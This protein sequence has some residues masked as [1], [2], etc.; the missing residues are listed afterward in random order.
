[1]DCDS[2]SSSDHAQIGVVK[3]PLA[4]KI[5][6]VTVENFLTYTFATMYPDENLNIVIGPNGT[7]KSSI[8]AGMVIGMGGSTKVLSAL[9]RLAD[10]VKNGKEM[11][12]ITVVLFK[13]ENRDVIRFCRSFGRNNKST[14]TI[15]GKKVTEITYLS[16]IR[17][18]N[19]QVS[20]LC[21]FLPQDRV[22]DFAKQ[23]P[24]ELFRSTQMSVCS[25]EMIEH[26]KQLTE[27]RTEQ[28]D[29]QTKLGQNA[30]ILKE[31]EKRLEV[32]Q[33][34]VD[35]IKR[36]G[37]LQTR[38]QLIEKKIAWMEF[39]K[40]YL[41]CKEID[42][43]L[44]VARQNYERCKKENDELLKSAAGIV[45]QR[46]KYENKLKSES[47][48]RQ[49][50]TDE[51]HRIKIEME[52]VEDALQKAIGDLSFTKQSAAEQQREL[53]ENQ[54]L[55][56]AC[57][58]D[59]SE[60]LAKTNTDEINAKLSVIDKNVHDFKQKINKFITTRSNIN[61]EIDSVIRPKIVE[62][63]N[64]I[65]KAESVAEVKLE[66]LRNNF[67][68][69]YKAVMWLREN[70]NLFKSKIYEPILLE[71]NIK[72]IAYCK[73]VENCIPIRDL[74][75]FTCEDVDDMTLLVEKLRI[76]M[77]LSCSVVHSDASTKL[78]FKSKAP[79]NQF[80]QYGAE[81]YLID[82]IDG[83]YPILNYLCRIYNVHNIV[84]GDENLEFNSDNLPSWMRV[85]FTP[86]SRISISTSKYSGQRSMLSNAIFGKNIIGVQTS[87][88]ELNALKLKKER[89]IRQ[90][91]KLR[92]DRNE[93]ER[94]VS[95][96]EEQC[97][98]KFLE[99]NDLNK[100]VHRLKQCKQ[101]LDMQ[102][103][104]VKRM[105]CDQINVDVE[106]EKFREKSAQLVKKM[107]TFQQNY[108]KVFE[109][110]TKKI[111]N[112][113]ESR[114]RFDKFKT[115]CA[116]IDG[117]IIDSNE[118]TERS[119]KYV[120]KIGGMLD[121]VKQQCFE[122]QSAAMKLTE[123]RKPSD[124]KRFPYK[125]QFDEL[126]NE[127]SVLLD[128]IADI[129]GQLDCGD[130]SNTN[131]MQEYEERLKNVKLLENQIKNSDQTAAQIETKIKQIHD[132]WYPQIMKI[133]DTINENFGS[134][135]STMDC[136]GEIELIRTDEHDYDKY[137][138]EI[139]VKYRS[140]ERLRALDRFVQS[141]GERAVAIAVYSLALQHLS[142]VPFRCVDEI[143]QGMDPN[144][145]RR[146]FEMLVNIVAQEGQSQFF[147]VTPKLLPNLAFNK[148]V[149]CIVVYNGPFTTHNG[150][151][152]RMG[153]LF[154][155]LIQ[156][157]KFIR[158]SLFIAM[159][160]I[161]SDHDAKSASKLKST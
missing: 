91:D 109:M 138:I 52:R 19:V 137:G 57:E 143:N 23:N 13:N 30:A 76:D 120:D 118:E 146:V 8:V 40:L 9:N 89:T 50:C 126:A 53:K 69:T 119:K 111:L 75:A 134:F 44:K 113:D 81:S 33:E 2:S 132:I 154:N 18:L 150:Y 63:E 11:S 72:N 106:T 6:S 28:L 4:G 80:R 85:F 105:E 54:L 90:S 122:K 104:K 12:Q 51:L 25:E 84:I 121:T 71:L 112:E 64:C 67:N 49:K 66:L 88:V 39:E 93:L 160:F 14:Y 114:V 60:H 79:I 124:G 59:Y 133:V 42:N 92:N 32:L 117:K 77:N 103:E 152:N 26:F 15:D 130:S 55:I 68:H 48:K 107:L 3:T 98:Q 5:F 156:K 128:E 62:M 37:N 45:A 95:T 99:K 43:D 61:N 82:C 123:N 135:M 155:E 41:K 136:A 127:M 147:Y 140:N 20:N 24:Q 27:M 101:K 145:E 17:A 10:Y 158:D 16:T 110:F 56:K 38:K 74:I 65:R 34:Q 97:N 35:T 131:T 94:L 108:V 148:F 78:N 29:S 102:K 1:M 115:S 141:G 100:V 21:Q 125:K 73:F 129:D 157:Q 83:P 47:D 22:Q 70:H 7:G 161:F 153:K 96:L 149:S 46:K 31:H 142:Q 159:F 144:N 151:F 36:Q 58:K 116:N 87:E 139:R 86:T